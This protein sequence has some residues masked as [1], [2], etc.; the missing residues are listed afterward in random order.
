MFQLQIDDRNALAEFVDNFRDYTAST[1][2]EMFISIKKVEE[3]KSQSWQL[4]SIIITLDNGDRFSIKYNVHNGGTYQ[5]T[6]K[7]YKYS[8]VGR[9]SIIA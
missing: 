5:Y 8:I 1:N 4:Q 7:E 6:Q 2:N 9:C 3:I